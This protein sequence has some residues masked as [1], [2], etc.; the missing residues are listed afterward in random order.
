[1]ALAPAEADAFAPGDG[2]GSARLGSCRPAEA[3]AMDPS[4]SGPPA[5]SFL[6]P[7]L[8]AT[9]DAPPGCRFSARQLLG[10]ASENRNKQAA[11]T[12]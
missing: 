9:V 7:E 4:P 8:S 11:T 5:G 1:M 2:P 6:W 12:K 3:A 10:A